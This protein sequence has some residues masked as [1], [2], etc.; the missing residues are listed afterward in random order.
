MRALVV[1][2]I[3]ASACSSGGPY[4]F[5]HSPGAVTY[6]D[7]CQVCHGEA[8]EGGLGPRLR[9]RDRD[10]GDLAKYIAANMPPAA[11]GSCTGDCARQVADFIHDGL[12]SSGLSCPAPVPL[13]RRLRLLTRREYKATVRDLFGEAA[14]AMA[15]ARA[16]DCAFHDTCTPGGCEPTACDAQTF[17]YDPHGQAVHTVHVAGD[18]NGWAGT[19][20]A[21]GL[22]LARDANGLYVGT[23]T[24]GAGHHAYKLVLD[25]TTWITDPRAPATAPDGFGGQNGTFELA[26]TG[27]TGG[28]PADPT[29]GFPA[30]ARRAGF[31]FDTDA[32]AALV[33]TAHVDAYLAAAEQ[34]A[35][36]AAADP[37][38]LLACDWAGQRATC[39]NQVATD[40][41]HRLFRRPL[42]PD[43]L[44]RYTALA[45]T[46]GDAKTGVATMLHAMLMSP[47]FLYRSELGVATEHGYTLTGDEVATALSYAIVGTTP[48]R[49]LLAAAERGELADA[50]GLERWARTL[51]A[52]PRARDQLG[53]F[54]VQWTNAKAFL[55][56]DKRADLFPEL[57]D[58]AR[59]SLVGETRAFT[60]D[61]VFDGG[62][63]FADLMTADYTVLDAP[64]AAFY[65]A[66]GTGHVALE[67]RTGLLGEAAVLGAAAH[68]DQTSPIV[69]GLLVRR[70]FLCEDLPP[71]P[72][73]GGTLPAVDP[74]A[75]TRERFQQHSASPQCNGCHRY[76]DDVGFGLETFDAVGRYRTTEH[77]KP[78]DAS[79]DLNDAERLGTGTHA[80]YA[81]QPT[82]AR[83]LA[84]SKTAQSCFVRQYLRFSR[85][86]RETLSERCGRLWLE[87]KL[88]G[89]HGDIKELVVQSFLDPDFVTRRAP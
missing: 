38:T 65:G 74:N 85:G 60:A 83:A 72:P 37:S 4:D 45:A 69:R 20:A 51:L 21:G 25:E 30:E 49:D 76:I 88:A 10:P 80:P 18:F 75:T 27:D 89:A 53:E 46:G 56:A 24:L 42:G 22:A 67:H 28:L 47:A 29:T 2:A 16:T 50:K 84:T 43:E 14:P 79:G 41:G 71:P 35:S 31:P 11:P 81:D 62:G 7:R 52:D 36:F 3:L 64:A 78:I 77:G 19:I 1:G 33:T 48:S 12:T 15:C 13:A 5:A 82:L 87:D 59:A 70:S 8:G 68:S 54:A 66:S 58:A 34:L 40:L 73:N 57:T 26:C 86:L 32:D 23:F 61:V 6:Q 55:T 17:V 63:T 39:S 44:A 9:D